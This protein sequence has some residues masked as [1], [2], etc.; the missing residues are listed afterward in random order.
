MGIQ[1]K[2]SLV[3]CLSSISYWVAPIIFSRR[4]FYVLSH[5]H[6]V[7]IVDLTFRLLL[8]LKK[9]NYWIFSICFMFKF[10]R[11]P[12]KTYNLNIERSKQKLRNHSYYFKYHVVRVSFVMYTQIFIS[13][14]VLQ[15]S[16]I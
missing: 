6:M 12:S 4:V 16:T 1:W 3:I 10:L 15:V 7:S 9:N 8:F 14:Y 11:E 13:Y 5:L 2:I